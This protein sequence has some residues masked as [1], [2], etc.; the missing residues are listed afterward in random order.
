MKTTTTTIRG[1]ALDVLV[2]ERMHADAAGVLFYVAEIVV[3]SRTTGAQR[4]VRRSR[5]P[6]TGQELARAVQKRGVRALEIF[7]PTA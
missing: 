1:L 5:I 7:S 4:V 3:R 2:I 6:G